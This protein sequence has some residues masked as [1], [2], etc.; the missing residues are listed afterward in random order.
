MNSNFTYTLLFFLGIFLFSESAM[1]QKVGSLPTDDLGDVSDNFQEFFFEAL[2]QKGIENYELAINAL[3][4]A[5][6]AAY[7]NEEFEAVVKFE[8]AK[9]LTKLK[10]Y[11][12]AEINFKKVLEWEADRLDVMEALYDV[13]YLQ[14]DY[15]SAIALVIKLI[16]FDSDYKEDLANLY[17]RS[18]Q[19]EKALVILDE[20]DEEWGKSS[21]RDALR[22]RIYRITGNS[23]KEINTLKTNIDK[24][25]K[26]EK[27]YLKLI[28]LYSDEGQKTK[29]FDTANELLKEHPNSQLVHL[30]LYK[31]Y[32]D[33]GNLIQAINSMKIVFSSEEID[34]DSKNRVLSDFL[35]YANKNPEQD[36]N[37][38]GIVAQLSDDTNSQ[39]YKLVGDYYLSKE[40][41]DKALA[42]YEKGTDKDIQNFELLKST[43]MLQIEFN[44]YNKASELSFKGLEVFPAQSVLYLLNGIA[45]NKLNKPSLA[46]ES[47]ETGLDYLFEDPKME[48]DFYQQ[49]IIAYTLKGDAK[50]AEIYTQK[51]SDLNGPN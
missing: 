9:N 29:A 20:L 32:L 43:I 15:D 1:S 35:S 45:S 6:N 22:S 47:L 11:E 19:Y 30:A 26:N 7:G 28:F 40:K 36:F 12:E 49:L 10:R 8:K 37:L 24:N 18:K 3:D 38:D 16:E 46:I 44:E 33:Q 25:Q 50:K 31:F 51:A 21:Y 13:Y 41:R 34:K 2:K 42:F 23:S 27:D 39:I 14:K 48:Y 17:N 4:K 5:H